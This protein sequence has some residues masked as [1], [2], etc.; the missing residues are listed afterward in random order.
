LLPP[1]NGF[2]LAVHIDLM[3]RLR[4]EVPKALEGLS[5]HPE[6]FRED[7]KKNLLLSAEDAFLQRRTVRRSEVVARPSVLC[8]SI[9]PRGERPDHRE[10]GGSDRK[11]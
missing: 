8:S 3:M 9:I 6:G 5:L 10:D 1:W 4:V 7:S 11:G 2:L